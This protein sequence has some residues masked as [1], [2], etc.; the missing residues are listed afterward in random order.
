MASPNGPN[1]RANYINTQPQ[2]QSWNAQ[3]LLNPRSYAV[4][5]A[6]SRRNSPKPQHLS[7]RSTPGNQNTTNNPVVFQFAS[8]NDTTSESLTPSI[9]SGASTPVHDGGISPYGMANMIERMNDVQDRAAAP[10]P[11]RRKVDTPDP[12]SDADNKKKMGP[13]GSGMLGAYVKEKQDEGK[14]ENSKVSTQTV[15]LTEEGD[16]VVMVE[17]PATEEVCY[18]MLTGFL[19]C[20]KV[21]SAKPGTQS[22]FGADFMPPVKI[23]LKRI[24]GDSTKKIQ[25]YDYTR[26]I[27]GNVDANTA[28]ALVPLLDSNVRLRTD[29]KIPARRKQA[30]EHPGQAISRSYPVE[31]TLYGQYRFVKAVGKHFERFKIV[32]RHPNRVDKGVRY[33]NVHTD[34][35]PNPA[36]G[37]RNLAGALAQYNN[38]SSSTYYTNP[39]PRTVEE[40]RSDVMGVFDSM[41]KTDELPE[42]DPAPIIT[43]ELLKHQKQGLYFMTAREKESTAEERV[44]GSMWQ[45]KIG[46][47][48]QK[49]YYNVITGHQERTLPADTHGGLLADMMGLGKTL[50]IL[51]LIG[52]SLDQA[53]EWAG[54]TPVQPEMPPQKA[55]G[56][57]TA[58][59]SL[60]LTGIAMNAKAT[61][62]VCPLSTVTNWE[63]QIK[64]HIAP[65]ELSYYIYH[66]SNR[67]KDVEKLAEFDLVITTYGSVSSELGARSKRKSGKYPLEEIGWFRIVLDEAHMIREVATLQFKA[68]VRLQAARRWAV[69][70]TPVQNRLEDLAALLQFVRLKPFDDRNK[71]NRFIVDPFKAC[72]TEIVPKL[73]VLVDSVTLRRLK[74]KINLP[75]RSDHIV[76]L[77]FTEEEREVYNLF[78]KN[79]QDR[80][81]VLS[82]NGVQKA[83]G[84]HTYIHILRSILR[85][86]LLCAH[87][88]D[89]LNQEDLEALQGM[90]ADM[91]IDLDSDDEDKK[92]GL[93]DRK[94]Y[95]MF[96]LMQETNTDACSACS[97]KIGTNDDASIESE[98]QED[99]LG[100]MTPCFHIICGSCIKGVKEQARRLLPPGQAMGPCPICST[101]IKP[102]YVDIRRSRV[103]VEH[104]GPAKEKTATNGRKS[105]GKYTGP[106]TKTR[107]LVEDLLKS[108][109]DTDANPNEPPYKSVV[110]S[111]WTSHLD[112]IQ[113]ALDNVGVKYVRLDG[114]MTRIARTQAMDSF[115]ED[116]SVHVILVSITAGGLGLNLTAGSNVYVMEPQ[117]NPAA[118]AQA[119]DRVHRL[120]QKRPVRTVCYIM[121]NSFEEK[122]L[123]LQEKKNKL[124]SLSMDRKERVFDKSEAARQRLL[125]LRSLFK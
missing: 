122:M 43:T 68:I 77:D 18:G 58:S 6:A 111:T 14:K 91:A 13:A 29:C 17:D 123:E 67:I 24:I 33:E 83:L 85:L 64:Q 87:G 38:H 19:D 26:D 4:S 90:T 1:G 72:D 52:S 35:K 53:K 45:L 118:E 47:T 89:L 7:N 99:I 39:T 22:I 74:D 109:A 98:G 49:F 114:S 120:G 104:E 101:V 31:M 3:A 37:A 65:G 80:V 79:A 56:K 102:A 105:F 71:F 32:L 5:N 60:P 116:H 10:L 9:T 81:K 25:A 48:G 73:R 11:K 2:T 88:K 51:S 113:M 50:S 107:A 8:P 78:E 62:L 92:P 69:T 103:K 54:R 84:G 70:G 75:P 82:G 117:Y 30:D 110:F 119:I 106:H 93:S 97:K 66:G 12:E 59:S 40:I 41:G 124:A 112:L 95:E 96:E 125:D 42:M 121:R 28:N 63:E 57:A 23:V 100:Y 86:R 16:D 94:A 55:G 36:P 61:L 108:K 46:P 115:R 44:K 27:I 76:K 15:D 20:H 21:P 34:N